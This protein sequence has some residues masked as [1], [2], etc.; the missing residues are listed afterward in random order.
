[1]INKFRRTFDVEKT[2]WKH[3]NQRE[4]CDLANFFYANA[5]V[6]IIIKCFLKTLKSATL[7]RIII[8]FFF[9]FFQNKNLATRSR[10]IRVKYWAKVDKIMI[11]KSKILKTKHPFSAKVKL[12]TQK[13]N[14]KIEINRISGQTFSDFC[15]N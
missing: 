5:G 14:L 3:L 8:F 6:K 1:M 9:F 2:L 10:N 12:K 4:I 15:A 7:N 13:L 11:K